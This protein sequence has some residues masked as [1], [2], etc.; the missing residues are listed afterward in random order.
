MRGLAIEF[1]SLASNILASQIDIP[2]DAESNKLARCLQ[3]HSQHRHTAK[4]SPG[5]WCCSIACS[6]A[7]SGTLIARHK[8]ISQGHGQETIDYEASPM[9]TRATAKLLR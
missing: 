6:L 2:G 4:P 5:R 8:R 1:Q 7:M 9:P 3:K